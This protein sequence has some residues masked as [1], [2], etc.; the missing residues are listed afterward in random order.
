MCTAS[1]ERASFTGGL[2]WLAVQGGYVKHCPVQVGCI[3]GREHPVRHPVQYLVVADVGPLGSD[4]E[5]PS[6]QPGH[7]CVHQGVR[8]VVDKQERGVRHVLS[9][10]RNAFERFAITW[11]EFLSGNHFLGQSLQALRTPAPQPDGFQRFAKFTCIAGR[12]GRPAWETLQEA[13]QEDPDSLGSC[14]LQQHLDNQQQ[15]R[16]CSHFSPREGPAI[17]GKPREQLAAER[18]NAL[19]GNATTW[20]LCHI[21][22]KIARR[23]TPHRPSLS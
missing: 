22:V 2:F 14:T 17:G 12:N 23:R 5:V 18:R 4:G 6:Q 7:A 9:D 13:R 16:T 15:V 8:L 20:W 19:P 21:H 10:C 1:P 3:S 11:P